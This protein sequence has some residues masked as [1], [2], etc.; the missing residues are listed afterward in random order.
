MSF[1]EQTSTGLREMPSNAAW[2][3]SRAL[4]P[5]EEVGTKSESA[6]SGIRDRGRRLRAALIDAAPVGGDSVELRMERARDASE[7]AREAEEEA[8]AAEEEALERSDYAERVREGGRARVAEVDRET[9]RWVKERITEAQKA[10]DEAVERERRAAEADAE[11]QQEQVQAE[12]DDEIDAA[13]GDAEG[14]RE[15]A[16]ELVEDA[17][18]KLAEARRLAEEAVEAAR[19][20]AEEASRQAQQLAD[21]AEQQSSY[22]EAQVAETEKLRKQARA[23]A[24]DG[25]GKL[26][27]G[28]T[29]GDLESYKKPQ[30]VELAAGIGIEG[31]TTMTK[32]ELVDAIAKASPTTR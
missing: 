5:V 8:V 27:G 7:R 1:S 18:E 3:V 19:A 32:G 2:L 24:K 4:K 29:N 26:K 12:V 17:T 13:Q 23:T 15:H 11:E 20:A 21:E 31:R 14:A 10:A 16:D 22:A 6:T 9:S 28:A 25:A 30:L